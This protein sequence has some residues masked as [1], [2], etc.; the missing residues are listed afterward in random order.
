MAMFEFEH[1]FRGAFSVN[2]GLITYH[3]G[4]LQLLIQ[5]KEDYP[6]QNEIGLPGK[7]ILPNEETEDAL[8]KLMLELIGTTNFY[9]KQLNAFTKVNRHPLGRVVCFTFYGLISFEKVKQMSSKLS[10]HELNNVP[11]LCYDH[12]DIVKLIRNSFRK[13][14]VRH[15]RV[16]EILP[17]E[18]VL[19]DILTIYKQA[20]LTKLEDSNFSKQIIKSELVKPINKTRK[21]FG[22]P[23]KLYT[24]NKSAIKKKSKEK[25]SFNFY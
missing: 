9:R 7:I 15:P 22:R 20:F 12:N 17:E 11:N 21:A 19:P 8:K 24:L 6:S 25:V 13:G 2:I 5:E 1:L 18:F 16:F 4:K 10:W 23:A 3:E 14:L